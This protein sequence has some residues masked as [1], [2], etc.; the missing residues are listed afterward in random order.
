MNKSD[1][2]KKDTANAY[3]EANYKVIQIKYRPN[4]FDRELLKQVAKFKG[5]SMSEFI[6]KAIIARIERIEQGLE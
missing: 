5:E 3:R 2:T 4:E 1:E 6:R